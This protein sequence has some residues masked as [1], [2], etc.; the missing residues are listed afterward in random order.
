MGYRHNLGIL[1]KKK[2]E[3]IKNMTVREIKKWYGEDYVP[4]YKITKEVY[5]LGKYYEGSFLKKFRSPVFAR[6]ATNRHFQ[7]DHEF[8]IIS[9]EGFEAII[10]QYRKNVLE[11]Y[12]GIQ[13]GKIDVTPLEVIDKKVRAWGENCEKYKIYPYSMD[14]ERITTSWEY[15][16]SVFELVRIYKSIDWE[17]QLVTITAW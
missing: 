11:Y 17:T 15:E 1:S 2:H 14:G 5:E 8:Y 7:G 16:Y 3:Q 9:K 10:E 4:C 12:V 6:T 13:S